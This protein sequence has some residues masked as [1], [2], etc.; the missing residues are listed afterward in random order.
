MLAEFEEVGDSR[1]ELSADG[2]TGCGPTPARSRGSSASCSTT[3]PAHGGPDGRIVIRVGPAPDSRASEVSAPGRA[4]RPV[5]P[6]GSSSA[7]ERGPGPTRTAAS[8]S[9]WPSAASS[10][11]DGRRCA[12][13][14]G[15]AG[16]AWR[17]SPVVGSSPRRS[18]RARCTAANRAGGSSQKRFAR[19]REGQ[20]R[21]ALEAAADVA[22]RVLLEHR[23]D[24][25]AL[26]LGG[27]RRALG[28]V[29][30]DPRLRPLTQLAS[31]RVLDVPD[32]R[33]AVLQRTPDMFRATI[34]RPRT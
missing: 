23:R 12:V 7:S 15:R 2:P 18:A 6:S 9:A 33:L 5:T 20:A 3:P 16:R 10:P 29:L 13:A 30:A 28:E 34:L 4:S 32:P 8:G 25:E 26:V 14:A 19:R 17:D 24:L 22:A 31:E 21:V 27:D 11:A 1:A